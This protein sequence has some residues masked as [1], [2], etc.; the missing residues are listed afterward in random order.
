VTPGSAMLSDSYDNFGYPYAYAD[1]VTVA[2]GISISRTV[3][4]EIAYVKSHY[5]AK[6]LSNQAIILAGWPGRLLTF[7]GVDDSVKVIIKE[8]IVGKGNVGY[9]IS[10]FGETANVVA[11]R[12]LFRKMYMTWR[13]TA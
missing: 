7:S 4:A 13:A 2:N 10:M 8:V 12:T 6:V 1:R 3:T 11:D 5:K 9:F